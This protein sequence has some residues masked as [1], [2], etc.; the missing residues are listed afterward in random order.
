MVTAI[1]AAFGASEVDTPTLEERLRAE[2]LAA[3]K[4][5]QVTW[6]RRR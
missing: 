5:R 2:E 6:I 3:E 4:Y 1:A